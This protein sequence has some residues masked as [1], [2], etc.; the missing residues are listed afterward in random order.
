[1]HLP[2]FCSREVFPLDDLFDFQASAFRQA[3]FQLGQGQAQDTVHILSLDLI[4]IHAGDVNASLVGA[5]Y[6]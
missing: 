5:V 6:F 1:M 3:L 2:G 4:G